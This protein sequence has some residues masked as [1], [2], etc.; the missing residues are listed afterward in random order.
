[1]ILQP[2]M[3]DKKGGP[4]GEAAGGPPFGTRID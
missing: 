3:S 1:M 2:Q 4:A